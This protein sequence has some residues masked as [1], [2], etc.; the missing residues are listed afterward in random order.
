VLIPGEVYCP[1]SCARRAWACRW[2]CIR[3]RQ[4]RGFSS[5]DKAASR[6]RW[7]VVGSNNV[8]PMAPLTRYM[9]A[10]RVR[11]RHTYVLPGMKIGRHTADEDPLLIGH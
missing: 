6:M 1:Y 11:Q 9:A 10:R 7:E 4:A 8:Q 3:C 2:T 5:G